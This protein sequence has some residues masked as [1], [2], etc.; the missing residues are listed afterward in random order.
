MKLR[1][2]ILKW[3]KLIFIFNFGACIRD[4]KKNAKH[5]VF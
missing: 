3:N 4:E 2:F 1:F 5:N